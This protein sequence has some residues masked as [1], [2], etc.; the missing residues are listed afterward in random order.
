[1]TPKQYYQAGISQ[2]HILYDPH[3]EVAVGYLQALYEALLKLSS[4]SGWFFKLRRRRTPPSTGVYLWGGV[5]RG[6]TWLMDQFYETAPLEAKQRWHFDEFMRF[7]HG[8]I[9]QLPLAPDPLETISSHMAEQ[10][11]LLCLDEFH[12]DDIGDAMLLAGLLD[13]LLSRGVILV[14]TSNLAPDELYKNGLQRSRF[15]P[16]IELIKRYCHIVPLSDDTDYRRCGPQEKRGAYP[17][18]P[19]ADAHILMR[20]N[21][22]ELSGT[23]PVGGLQELRVNGRRIRV[24]A[25]SEGV[26]W[27]EFDAL[28][29]SHRAASDYLELADRFHTLLITQVPVLEGA[30]DAAAQRFIHLVDALY[31]ND[32]RLLTTLAAAPEKIYGGQRLRFSFQRVVSRLYEMAD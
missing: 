23:E 31:D 17:V 1:M 21:Y 30:D 19:A 27:S 26:L 16:A 11:R 32:V 10:I 6:K 13:G 2:K 7:V 20:K 12:V 25:W 29:A 9:A 15:L 3:Q 4:R 28:C 8:K 5:G 14:A 24:R 18:V 22:T